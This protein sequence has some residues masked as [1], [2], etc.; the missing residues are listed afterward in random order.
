M[1]NDNWS[2]ESIKLRKAA[3]QVAIENKMTISPEIYLEA[4]EE[5]EFLMEKLEE[6]HSV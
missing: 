3:A 6:K 5:I 2:K 4:I 1:A